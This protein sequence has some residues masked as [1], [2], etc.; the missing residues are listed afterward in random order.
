ML[1]KV[2]IIKTP[3]SPFPQRNNLQHF[4]HNS[5]NFPPI[6]IIHILSSLNNISLNKNLPSNNIKILNKRY[7]NRKLYHITGKVVVYYVDLFFI[8]SDSKCWDI[9][10]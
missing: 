9:E 3:A 8:G 10:Y 6:Q 2:K 1:S 5:I 7:Y 4:L